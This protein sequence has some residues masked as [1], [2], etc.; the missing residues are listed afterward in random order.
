MEYFSCDVAARFVLISVTDRDQLARKAPEFEDHS[1]PGLN[2][3]GIAAGAR[4]V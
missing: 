4:C 1:L 3:V 2:I